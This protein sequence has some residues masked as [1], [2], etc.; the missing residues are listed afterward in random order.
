MLFLFCI[1]SFYETCPFSDN[2][3]RY[4]AIATRTG[5]QA[6]DGWQLLSGSIEQPDQDKGEIFMLQNYYKLLTGHEEV[7]EFQ[8]CRLS[9]YSKFLMLNQAIAHLW[10]FVHKIHV[11]GTFFSNLCYS[12]VNRLIKD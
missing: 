8:L 12:L 5:A 10:C 9:L 3:Q 1:I 7:F 4:V 11:I 6:S 2:S